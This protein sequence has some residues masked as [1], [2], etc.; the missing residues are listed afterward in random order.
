MVV[1]ATTIIIVLKVETMKMTEKNILHR[2]ILAFSSVLNHPSMLSL[3]FN[4]SYSK[5]HFLRHAT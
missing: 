3:G 1:V 4:I 5:S 2:L